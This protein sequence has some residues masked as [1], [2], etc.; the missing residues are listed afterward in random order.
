MAQHTYLIVALGLFLGSGCTASQNSTPNST[1]AGGSEADPQT[2]ASVGGTGGQDRT[3]SSVPPTAGTGGS[4]AV[5][6]SGK[7][8]G[9]WRASSIGIEVTHS[10]GISYCS[11]SA[12][13]C[14][15]SRSCYAISRDRM[16]ELQ[17]QMLD[18]LALVKGKAC[19]LCDGWDDHYLSVLDQDGSEIKYAGPNCN[20][21][22][23]AADAMISQEFFDSFPVDGSELCP[24]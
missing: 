18:T 4:S 11:A 1:T 24:G 9:I 17:I 14:V 21:A 15:S 10:W 19:Y 8:E 6:A 5:G 13:G 3:D 2:D 16:S 12:D 23:A 7:A 22:G 20:C